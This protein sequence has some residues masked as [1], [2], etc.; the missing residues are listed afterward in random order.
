MF[1]YFFVFLLFLTPVLQN[2]A[3]KY[4]GNVRP[5]PIIVSFVSALI[6]YVFIQL[7]VFVIERNLKAELDAF[8]LNG[9]GFFSGEEVTPEQN[10]A[11]M[12][13][14]G[15]TARTFAPITGGIFCFLYFIALY[16]LLKVSVW[17]KKI[18][19]I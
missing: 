7:S 12:R 17:Y 14:I 19:D 1:F 2:W 11:M 6:I 8:D 13:V 18:D 15:D 10:A 4:F 16:F 5:R 3:F 9:D